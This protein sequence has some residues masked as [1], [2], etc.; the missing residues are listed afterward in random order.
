MSGRSCQGQ[1]RPA[2]SVWLRGWRADHKIAVHNTGQSGTRTGK[3]SGQLGQETAQARRLPG[4]GEQ[5]TVSEIEDLPGAVAS[6]LCVLVPARHEDYLGPRPAVV[7]RGGAW[8]S[9]C[10]NFRSNLVLASNEVRRNH[11]ISHGKSKQPPGFKIRGFFLPPP[12]PPRES[13]A[14]PPARRPPTNSSRLA[15]PGFSSPS[16]RIAATRTSRTFSFFK[17][18]I[19]SATALGCR[20]A[21]L[22]DRFQ[23]LAADVLVVVLESLL[24]TAG[25]A[26]A[27]AGPTSLAIARRRRDANF[28][29]LVLQGSNHLRHGGL[30]PLALCAV[31]SRDDAP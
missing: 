8:F 28:G 22:A 10:L 21:E 31:A 5:Q 1:R 27:A 11:R 25:K 20:R 12:V 6:R 15:P 18:L 29:V 23:R 16:A 7:A 17:Q 14:D 4:P 9:L 30:G 3:A 26:A 13:R 2:G 24:R 19:T